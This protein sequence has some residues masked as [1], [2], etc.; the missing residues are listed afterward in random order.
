M[1]LSPSSGCGRRRSTRVAKVISF[2]PWEKPICHSAALPRSRDNNSRREGVSVAETVTHGR[3]GQ[4]WRFSVRLDSERAARL[5]NFSSEVGCAPSELVRRLLDQYVA[6]RSPKPTI[7]RREMN[8]VSAGVRPLPTA[9]RETPKAASAACPSLR[10]TAIV[11][12]API[13]PA[14]STGRTSSQVP[15]IDELVAQY[16]AFGGEIWPERRRLFQRLF[17]AARVA[18][19]NN[20]NPKDFE[21]YTEL[22]RLG[23]RFALFN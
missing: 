14:A 15:K 2:Q 8:V 1:S 16:R 13:A 4:Q 19:E 3:V 22:L 12:A 9:T 5:K 20:E 23:Q 17:A 10:L 7:Q 18:Q 21:L 6:S 11:R